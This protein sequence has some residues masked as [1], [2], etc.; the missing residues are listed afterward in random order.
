MAAGDERGFDE[1]GWTVAVKRRSLVPGA[2]WFVQR[3]AHSMLPLASAD[4][5]RQANLVGRAAS[6][7]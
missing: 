7:K 2:R 6:F 3:N 1:I 4:E 5:C